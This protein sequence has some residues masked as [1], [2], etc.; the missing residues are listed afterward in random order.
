MENQLTTKEM[1]AALLA[2]GWFEMMFTTGMWGNTVES[3]FWRTQDAF[4]QIERIN[5]IRH[6][7]TKGWKFIPEEN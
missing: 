4:E 2:N 3:G 6:D 1:E 5:Q 7:L